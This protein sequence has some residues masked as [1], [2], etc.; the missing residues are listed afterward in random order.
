[1]KDK[2]RSHKHLDLEKRKMI[3]RYLDEGKT[4]ARVAHDLGV[5]PSTIH[6]EIRR[7][8]RHEGKSGIQSA[9]KNDCEHLRSC[10]L[11]TLCVIA[12]NDRACKTR[13]CKYC[14]KVKCEKHCRDYH[15]R[16]CPDVT[17]APFVCNGCGHY[18]RCTVERFR[19]SAEGAQA[20]SD[21]RNR[22]A[23]RGFDLTP[24]EAD[25]LVRI[26]R[27]GL[28][29]GHSIHHIFVS[30]KMPCSER[31]FYR[32]VENEEI[33]IIS[34]E[35]AKKVKYK[36]RKRAK[37]EFTHPRGFYKGHEYKDY[38]DL[39][40]P[41]RAVT[42]EI[43]TVWGCRGDKKCILSI[44]RIDLHFQIYLLLKAK[45][46]KEV[47]TA[48]NWL[49]E[50]SEG[51]FA[52]LFGLLLPDRGSEFDDIEGMEQ[53]ALGEEKRARTFFTDP[54]RPDQKGSAEKNHVELR[55]VVPKGTSL[56]AMD[57][58]TLATICS[59][60]NSTIRKGCGDTSPMELA[61]MCFSQAL[62]DN[63]GLS[64]IPPNEVI[65]APGV[66]YYPNR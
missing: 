4:F 22:E 8:R 38:L 56:E 48:L 58:A 29:R 47:V 15:R 60:V 35:L 21:L 33:G 39:S 45:T 61:M 50:C 3:E 16:V 19:Y 10:K 52:E 23:R 32:L 18:S 54:N 27:S 25:Y 44:H 34:L 42:T 6:R 1:M 26:V 24:G 46:T 5:D 49:E 30:N 66:L 14:R 63:L 65:S 51:R 7:N 55:K 64:L 12:E 62:F 41:E 13:Y 43:D 28:A 57:A 20:S 59:H 11:K 37:V 36:K 31:T 40:L 17:R 2:K 53:S 9:D